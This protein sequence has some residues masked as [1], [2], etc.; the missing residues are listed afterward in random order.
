MERRD[1]LQLSTAGLA[2][3]LAASSGCSTGASRPGDAPAVDAL[4]RGTPALEA[5]SSAP[6][7]DAFWDAVR[8]HYAPPPGYLDLDHANTAPTARPVFDAFVERARRLSAGPA[9]GFGTMW[10][11][12][13][14]AV[15]RPALA[16]Y[17]GTKPRHLAFM[18]NTTTALNTVLHGFAMRAGDEIL[19]TDHEYPDMVETVHQRSRRD[20]L[21][22][23]T[24]RVPAPG[25]DRLALVDRVVQSI[26][27]RTRLLL[28]SHVSAWSGEVLPVAEVTAAAR[29]RGVAVLVDAAQSVGLLDVDFE[30][31]GCDFLGASLHKGLGAPLPT[32]VLVMR[33]E[34]MRQVDPLHP[35]SWLDAKYPMDQYE[36][37]GT[38]NMAGLATATDALAFQRV[39]GADRKRARLRRLGNHWQDRMQALPGVTVLTPRDPARSFGTGAFAVAGLPSQALAKRLRDRHAILVQDKSGRH[40]PFANAI[41][42]SPGAHATFEELD[43]LVAAVGEEIRAANLRGA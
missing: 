5:L 6:S 42:V 36:W 26:T 19:V 21:S 10:K 22:V 13:L 18:A 14:E 11:D 32:G 27:P 15:A 1:F 28:I 23:R 7:D 31:L 41:R 35:P 39:L 9:E 37:S 12:E 20:G 43:R 17:L 29:A 38:F 3:A 25:E 40:S 33:P 8:G 4:P 24:V 34:R 16:A 30:A 2:G